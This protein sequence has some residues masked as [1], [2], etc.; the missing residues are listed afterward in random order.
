MTVALTTLGFVA[1]AYVGDLSPT[2]SEVTEEV[3]L[4]LN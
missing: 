2:R 4:T 3:T 1:F